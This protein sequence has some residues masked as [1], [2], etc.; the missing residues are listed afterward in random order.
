MEEE[1]NANSLLDDTDQKVEEASNKA[2][3]GGR[4]GPRKLRPRRR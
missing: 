1:A 4:E 3:M 2:I